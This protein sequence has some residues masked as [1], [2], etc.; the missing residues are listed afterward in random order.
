[1]CHEFLCYMSKLNLSYTKEPELSVQCP[2]VRGRTHP[3]SHPTW[4]ICNGEKHRLAKKQLGPSLRRV[5]R[6]AKS[7]DIQRV[8][9]NLMKSKVLWHS[10]KNNPKA[11]SPPHPQLW[12]TCCKGGPCWA[13]VHCVRPQCASWGGGEDLWGSS[14]VYSQLWKIWACEE[15][16]W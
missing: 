1:M 3:E 16:D 11:S 7:K 13:S 15:V 8:K 6:Q 12:A 9:L 2:R 5:K 10:R 4:L 14:D